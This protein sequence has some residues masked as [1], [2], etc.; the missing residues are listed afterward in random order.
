MVFRN[1]SYKKSRQNSKQKSRKCKQIYILRENIFS[2]LLGMETHFNKCTGKVND[3][4]FCVC[5][6][7]HVR[8]NTFLV[9][10]RHI[11]KSHKDRQNQA[12]TYE[13]FNFS[14]IFLDPEPGVETAEQLRDR[15]LAESR[16]ISTARSV[17]RPPKSMPR[18]PI[19]TRPDLQPIDRSASRLSAPSFDEDDQIRAREKQLAIQEAKL[20]EYQERVMRYERLAEEATKVA[21]KDKEIRLKKLAEDL[22]EREVQA[23]RKLASAVE[24]INIG[25]SEPTNEEH[26]ESLRRILTFESE[27]TTLEGKF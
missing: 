20:R 21:L 4:D 8:F 18:P 24:S 3:G 12:K 25:K 16:K 13:K 1:I 2:F 26:A 27:R 6:I 9:K 14:P 10:E 7:C 19:V 15:I 22:R 23:K 5:E 17:G 11:A